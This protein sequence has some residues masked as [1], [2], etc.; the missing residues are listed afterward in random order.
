MHLERLKEEIERY[1]SK[2]NYDLTKAKKIIL[3]NQEAIEGW[4]KSTKDLAEND[5]LDEGYYRRSVAGV[6]E[7]DD[8]NYYLEIQKMIKEIR[9]E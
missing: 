8:E 1:C 4:I 7:D 2:T 9:N 5:R 3:G 6:L